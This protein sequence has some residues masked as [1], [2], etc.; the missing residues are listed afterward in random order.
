MPAIFSQV[1]GLT[2]FA[3]ARWLGFVPVLNAASC[4]RNALLGRPDWAL[5]GITVATS[6]VLAAAA[7]AIAVRLFERE[8]VLARI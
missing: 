4:I 5:F 8:E 6:L 1:I 3:N 2:D 7:L